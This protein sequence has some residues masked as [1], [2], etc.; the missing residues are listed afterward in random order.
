ADVFAGDAE[1]ETLSAILSTEVES[2]DA[3]DDVKSAGFDLNSHIE[4]TLSE[5]MSGSAEAD[6]S[7]RFE[8]VTEADSAESAL[9][10]DLAD[11]AGDADA[12]PSEEASPMLAENPADNVALDVAPELVEEPG[13]EPA[14]DFLDSLGDEDDDEL[15]GA[16][17]AQLAATF[18]EFEPF[19]QQLVGAS[20]SEALDAASNGYVEV[21]ERVQI[22]AEA[23][24]LNGFAIIGELLS[25]NVQMLPDMEQ[26][27][28]AAAA[29]VL[30]EWPVAVQAYFNDP[31][32][33]AVQITLVE[34]LTQAGWPMPVPEDQ[35]DDMLAALSPDP[36]DYLADAEQRPTVAQ[37]DDV[38]LAIGEDVNP[39]LVTVFMHE[40]PLNAADFSATIERIIRGDDIVRNLS[41]A[42][43]LAHN[44]K[45][46]ANMIGV[47][48]IANMTHHVEDI[49]EY[50]TEHQRAPQPE[51]ARTLQEAADCV[52]AMLESLQSGT[53]APSDAQHILQ[54]VFDWANRMDAGQLEAPVVTPPVASEV[55]PAAPAPAEAAT[56]VAAPKP[57]PVS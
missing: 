11:D 7:A 24:G 26:S 15:M 28:R 4:S 52:E 27:A 10:S 12:I 33:Q 19:R 51:L 6:S 14:D 31:A 50:L 20:D 2:S 41:N 45:G 46:S 43:R 32:D 16:L 40:S 34:L 38:V 30:A 53:E 42:Q 23:V 54:N 55:A 13:D 3:E 29:D 48:G 1:E 37:P 35:I 49:L 18:D 9:T 17:Q 44:I 47:K 57:A 8:T 56:A 21:I 36:D 22:A 5:P 39:K 25:A